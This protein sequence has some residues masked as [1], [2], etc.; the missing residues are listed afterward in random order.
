MSF[1]VSFSI[2]SELLDDVQGYA[3]EDLHGV[4]KGLFLDWHRRN[5]KK[6]LVGLDEKLTMHQHEMRIALDDRIS[7]IKGSIDS[8]HQ[9]TKD[10]F[11]LSKTSQKR[12]E[13]LENN[14]YKV[15]QEQ[16]QDYAFERTNH[17]PHHADARMVTPGGGAFLIELKNYQNLVD[18]KEVDK[19]KYDMRHTKTRHALFVSVQSAIAGRKAIDVERFVADGVEYSIVFVSYVFEEAHKLHTG[20]AMVEALM[21]LDGAKPCGRLDYLE[22]R[23][24]KTMKE[25]SCLADT[26]SGIRAR[27]MA[28]E[29]SVRDQ[30]SDFYLIVREHE[31]QIKQRLNHVWDVITK[32]LAA[33]DGALI[34]FDDYDVVLEELAGSECFG[35]MSRLVEL[36]KKL[37]YTVL[38]KDD[39]TMYMFHEGVCRGEVKR[40]RQ[41]LE[42]TCYEP[43][44]TLKLLCKGD[45]E[46]NLQ[47]LESVL[48]N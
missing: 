33:A 45:N 26:V 19:L 36:L 41:K 48:K 46:V 6:S 16:F 17:L 1:T 5:F 37:Q 8:L 40:F 28:L 14:V 23:V 24:L 15:F 20:I 18:Q 11:G 39:T 10:V 43:A 30:M 29:K 31:C 12:G 42:V 3:P 9:V 38:K 44:M 34:E 32:D 35:V 21:K 13:I 27:F 7:G 22:E 4:A 25:I 2:P 47:F